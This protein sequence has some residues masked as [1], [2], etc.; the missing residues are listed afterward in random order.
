MLEGNARVMAKNEE[1]RQHAPSNP[2]PE[3]HDLP[4]FQRI[5]IRTR[6]VPPKLVVGAYV[7]A[8]ASTSI[9]FGDAATTAGIVGILCAIASLSGWKRV[10]PVFMCYVVAFWIARCSLVLSDHGSLLFALGDVGLL[11]GSVAFSAVSF[12]FLVA[13][14]DKIAT[15]DNV[16]DVK[17]AHCFYAVLFGI[18]A[19]MWPLYIGPFRRLPT[20]IALLI[21]GVITD[22]FSFG[23]LALL[24]KPLAYVCRE[25]E[26]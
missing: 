10:F 9:L 22:M 19:Y 4:T 25:G 1:K 7:I 14:G 11:T 8:A 21:S 24:C 12:V 2:N 20:P 5:L 26:R 3:G 17:L 6:V 23:L 18:S 15:S 13:S 16:D